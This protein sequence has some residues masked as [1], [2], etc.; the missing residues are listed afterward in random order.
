MKIIPHLALAALLAAAALPARAEILKVSGITAPFMDVSLGL[1]EAGIIHEQFFKEG[2]SVQKGAVLLDLDNRLEKLEV[3]RRKAVMD[4]NKLVLDSTVELSKTTTSVSKVDLAKAEA[5][6][7]VSSAEYH[8]AVQQLANRQ[9]VAP[10]SGAITEILLKPGAA[11]A[12]YQSVVRLVDT[13]RCYFV[14]HLDGKAIGS[15]RLDQPVS[16]EL[17]GGT[18][19][20]AKISFISP[21]VDAASGLARVKAIFE[22][23]D[24]KIR[25]GLAAKMTAE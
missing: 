8:I 9:L 5:E 24:G 11:V 21:V 16:I 6:Y 12:P 22:N 17:E 20:A 15:L 4:H 23:P 18:T 7:N 2:D 13:S 14:G 1:A 25:P 19:V 10:F 3:D